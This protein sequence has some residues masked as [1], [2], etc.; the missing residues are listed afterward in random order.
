MNRPTLLPALAFLLLSSG[1]ALL[2]QDLDARARA[3]YGKV[4]MAQNAMN[5]EMEDDLRET[6]MAEYRTAVES[7]LAEWEPQAD[8]LSEGLF[9]LGRAA[10]Q[11]FAPERA[12]TYF[13][14]YLVE[15]REGPHGDEAQMFLGDA[16]RA[17]GQNDRAVALYTAF[18]EARPESKH[19]P[20]AM[21]GLATARFLSLD[22]EAAVRGY[23]D[24]LKRFPESDLVADAQMQLLNALIYG[25]RP[26][27]AR[28][29]LAKLI[30]LEPGAPE[31]QQ[32][33][34]QL[35]LIGK[36]APA[37]TGILDWSGV[38]GSALDRMRGRVVVLVF[39][40]T[41][42]IPCARSLQMLSAIEKEMRAEGVTV[43]GLSKAYKLGKNDWKLEDEMRWLARY[44]ENPATV[45]QRELGYRPGN[46][47]EETEVWKPLAEPIT[48]TLGLT[49]DFA[50]HKAYK[51][52]RVPTI[53]LVDKKGNLRLIEEGGQPEGGFQ[54]KM[55]RSFIA[56]LAG[57]R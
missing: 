7:F 25:D 48:A 12:L 13:E 52:R 45:I 16:Y 47:D 6:L 56:R 3:D 38:P 2:A 18:L 55:L 40:R 36:E 57:E 14:K 24:L 11:A 35:E 37:L 34:E 54:E 33:A 22:F 28:E 8:R 27:E 32:R 26:A 50:N 4:E 42:H 46:D 53:A 39:F 10:I 17:T 9:D 51:V 1:S 49:A 20:A 5:G 43:W 44:R 30:E 29:H 21:L 15:H 31:L 23:R 41:K 19:A